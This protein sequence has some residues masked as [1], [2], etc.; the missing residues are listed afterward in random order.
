MPKNN[1]SS[2][3]WNTDIFFD[4]IFHTLE[5]LNINVSNYELDHLCYRV[6]TTERYEELKKI[7]GENWKL[8]SEKEINGRPI[9]T[10]KL[11]QAIQYGGREIS[12]LELPSPKTGSPYTEW[13]EH[14][15]FVIDTSFEDFMKQYP[16]IIFDT[17]S[18][19]KDINHDIGI[20]YDAVRVKFHHNSL[21]YVVKYL[22]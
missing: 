15:E 7:F 21:E 19:N 14:V 5:S 9:C 22:E 10:F 13:L 18:M 3:L 1:T 11:K 4:T 8:L 17:K 20:E 6:E 16:D 12:V 2:I